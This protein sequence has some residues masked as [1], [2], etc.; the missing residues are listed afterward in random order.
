[1]NRVLDADDL[2]H[3]FGR[4]GLH[5]ETLRH[6]DPYQVGQVIFLSEREEYAG[7]PLATSRRRSNTLL[8]STPG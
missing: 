6:S 1:M 4:D 3:L 7:E 2:L 8:H 5:R